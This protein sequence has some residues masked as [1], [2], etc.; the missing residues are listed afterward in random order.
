MQEQCP[1]KLRPAGARC[2]VQGAAKRT[3]TEGLIQ[4]PLLG[5]AGESQVQGFRTFGSIDGGPKKIPHEPHGRAVA[6]LRAGPVSAERRFRKSFSSPWTM[7]A[8]RRQRSGG[9]SRANSCRSAR[10]SS[11]RRKVR[12]RSQPLASNQAISASLPYL[13]RSRR[14]GTSRTFRREAAEYWSFTFQIRFRSVQLSGRERRRYFGAPS[15]SSK[16]R[17]SNASPALSAVRSR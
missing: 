2:L 11:P 17:A 7:A 5:P 9:T 4:E 16:T 13:L 8:S 10:L 15:S 3:A 6:R 12:W 14:T 1:N